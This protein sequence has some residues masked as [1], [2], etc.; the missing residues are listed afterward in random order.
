MRFRAIETGVK[1]RISALI[2]R[3]EN[4]WKTLDLCIFQDS[5]SWRDDIL[6][7]CFSHLVLNCYFFMC[8]P[9]NDKFWLFHF[10]QVST[11]GLIL[12]N[13]RFIPKS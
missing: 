11:N 9:S 7:I 13:E 2:S 4:L 3:F 8:Y 10:R 12:S 1:I 5:L 6:S